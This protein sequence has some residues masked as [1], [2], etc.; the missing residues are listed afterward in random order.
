MCVVK[1]QDVVVVNVVLGTS[2][3]VFGC[4]RVAFS[5]LVGK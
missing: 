4:W 2:L 3:L 1:S 5:L